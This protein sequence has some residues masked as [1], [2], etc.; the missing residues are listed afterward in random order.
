[1][2]EQAKSVDKAFFQVAAVPVVLRSALDVV[3]H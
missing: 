3:H 2:E 1:M